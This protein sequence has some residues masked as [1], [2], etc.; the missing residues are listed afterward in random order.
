MLRNIRELTGYRIQVKDDMLGKVKDFYFDDIEWNIR[1]LVA[2]TGGWLK[3]RRVLIAPSSLGTPNWGA[4]ILPVNLMK[5]DIEK[6]PDVS[7]YMPVSLEMEYKLAKYYNWPMYWTVPGMI[8]FYNIPESSDELKKIEK[9]THL[10]S[11]DEVIGYH[12]HAKDGEIGHVD[13]FIV[14]DDTWIIRYMLVDTR[15]WLP[16]RKVLISPQWIEKIE[17]NEKQVRI[18][19]LRKIIENGPEYDGKYPVSREYENQLYELYGVRK[20]W[21]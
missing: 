18:L 2:D 11:T 3:G 9:K 16:G 20:Y 6:S 17:W 21:E 19:L 14:E 10:R 15:N 12:I 1:Y 7:D 8:P 4:R 5:A 13:D